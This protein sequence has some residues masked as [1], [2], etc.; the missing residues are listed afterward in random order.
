MFKVIG[1]AYSIETQKI[2]AYAKAQELTVDYIDLEVHPDADYWQ[3]W[4]KSH[5]ILGIPVILYKNN[6]A[7]GYDVDA[8]LNLKKLTSQN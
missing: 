3:L 1:K 8:F 6:F 5:K 7:V 4:L 2:L